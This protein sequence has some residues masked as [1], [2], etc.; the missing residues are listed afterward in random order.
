MD[1]FPV[2][3]LL[4]DSALQM[5]G[6][7]IMWHK[8]IFCPYVRP[9]GTPCYDEKRGSP[10]IECPICG[11][12]GVVYASPQQIK[13][14]YTDNSNRYYP[15]GAGGFMQGDKTLS[16]S[17]N[18]DISMLKAR[19]TNDARRLLRDKF[20]VLGRCCNPDGTREVKEVLYLDQ[21]PTEPTI[22]S[23]TIY[24]IVPVANN[25]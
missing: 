15:D 1:L 17:R 11:G 20:E 23:G 8:A 9:D 5:G 19:D 2:S 18:L 7:D 13:A 21:D 24:Q 6:T 16:V 22:N 4:A 25:Y 14:I 10:W 12:T 3:N